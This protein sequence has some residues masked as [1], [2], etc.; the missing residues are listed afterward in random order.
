[1]QRDREEK[2]RWGRTEEARK[3]Y[4]SKISRKKNRVLLTIGEG[5]M[6]TT[7]LIRHVEE[8]KSLKQGT[9]T[10]IRNRK[11]GDMRKRNV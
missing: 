11:G 10:V 6:V 3:R 5:E 9:S 4:I 1:L 8:E 7:A 2:G